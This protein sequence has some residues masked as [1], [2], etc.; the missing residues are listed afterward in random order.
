LAAEQFI[1]VSFQLTYEQSVPLSAYPGM[2][3]A[4]AVQLEANRDLGDVVELVNFA[5]G[6]DPARPGAPTLKLDRHV[7]PQDVTPGSVFNSRATE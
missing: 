4:E 5:L 2:S 3:L 1:K 7:A 6:E